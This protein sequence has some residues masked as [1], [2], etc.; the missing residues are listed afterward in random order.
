VNGWKDIASYLGKG[1]RTAQR[2]ERELGMPVH[3]IT[4]PDGGQIV[5]A[6]REELDA[7]LAQE[8]HKQPAMQETTPAPADAPVSNS[9]TWRFLLAALGLVVVG[10]AGLL[11]SWPASEQAARQPTQFELVGSELVARTSADEVA[12]RHSFGTPVS[13]PLSQFAVTAPIIPGNGS[14]AVI[15][16][17]RFGPKETRQPSRSD[18]VAAF[19]PDGTELWRIDPAFDV[20]V[21]GR[22]I[23]GPWH[24]AAWAVG[25]GRHAG[26]VWLAFKHHT[27]SPGIVLEVGARG[28]WSMRYVQSGWVVGLAQWTSPAGD[29]LVAG[30]VSNQHGR[31]SVSLID[32]EAAPAQGPPESEAR[33]ECGGCP[34][35]RPRAFIL[36]PSNEISAAHG[37]AYGF[38]SPTLAT[39]D[40]LKVTLE[41]SVVAF[42][43][44]ALR[45]SSISLGDNFWQAHRQMEGRGALSH[46][47]GLCP[48]QSTMRNIR[49]WTA[50][51]GWQEYAADLAAHPSGGIGSG[52]RPR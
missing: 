12:W 3:R 10:A 31:A 33:I 42:I 22:H 21:E 27:W 47:E 35:G 5:Y 7:W 32:L 8:H 24:F 28:A 44:P 13:Q 15:V 45:V 46:S 40:A 29:F 9:R 16:P 14:A 17:I 6:Y 39:S 23:T 38:A 49:S 1:V 52:G 11:G 48:A 19:D 4:G 25:S 36:F 30:G 51:S 43:T 2:W 50:E 37:A 20:T 41:Y 18:I 26:T 34:G